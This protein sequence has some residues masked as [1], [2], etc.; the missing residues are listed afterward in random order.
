MSED[1]VAK[2]LLA[3]KTCETCKTAKGKGVCAS[4]WGEAV[5]WQVGPM[6]KNDTCDQWYEHDPGGSK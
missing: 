3:D 6:N 1:E 4:W 5:G 2:N